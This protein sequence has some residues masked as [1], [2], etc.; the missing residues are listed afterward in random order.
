[1]G[2]SKADQIAALSRV[3]QERW[4]ETLSLEEVNDLARRPWWLVGRPE[5]QQPEGD[6]LIW[7]I[8]SGR[9]WGKTRTGAEWIANEAIMNP[10]APD[11]APSEFAIIAETFSDTRV[12]CVEGPSGI[13][14]VLQSRGLVSGED[15]VYN[16]SVYQIW[17]K[18]G[19]K[20]HMFGGDNPDAGRGLNLSGVWADEIAKWRY[21]YAS[22][23]EGIAPALRI[24][25]RPRAVITT[26]PKPIKILKDWVG[27]SDGSVHVTRGSTFDNET[28]L[29]QVALV[30]L[31]SRYAGTRLGQ[32]E[33]YGVMLEEVEGA[34]WTHQRIES[35]R[36][37]ADIVP[38]LIRVVVGVDPAASNNP[39]SDSTGIVI[40]GMCSKREFYVL[41]DRTLKATPQGWGEAAVGAYNEFHADRIVAEK[42]NGGDMVE[43]TLRHVDMNVP[44]TLVWASKGKK[45]RAEPISAL[46]EQGRVHHVGFMLELEAQMCEWVPLSDRDQPSPDRLDALVWALTDLTEGSNS[47]IG[48]SAMATMCA[49]CGMPNM[50]TATLCFNCNARL[51]PRE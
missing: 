25:K 34:L 42:N 4:L 17:F 12:M 32:Q 40:V 27:R 47:I 26:T 33:L 49:G 14:R 50:K 16:K 8:L 38:P 29:S 2:L 31:K 44:V 5:Q 36:I 11:G 37:H 41:G 10:K 18:D 6:W 22:W 9:G 3:D 23:Y 45:L 19:Q 21:A 35:G 20:I 13:L 24:G 51:E 46:Y 30:E 15:F 39:N 28:N 43:A 7:L 48:L 1:M